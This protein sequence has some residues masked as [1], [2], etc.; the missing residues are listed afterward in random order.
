MRPPITLVRQDDGSYAVPRSNLV[1]AVLAFYAFLAAL[2]VCIGCALAADVPDSAAETVRRAHE[3]Q[4]ETQRRALRPH[5][6]H[7]VTVR[8]AGGS[9][10]S[11]TICD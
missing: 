9:L 10:K 6:C 3:A 2:G 7:V 4:A 8:V 11:I 1:G 5:G